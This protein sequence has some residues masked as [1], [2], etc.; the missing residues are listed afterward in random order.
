[1]G[2][3]I[4]SE[5]LGRPTVNSLTQ[6]FKMTE[7]PTVR[8]WDIEFTRHLAG[9]T[10][11]A[12]PSPPDARLFCD[13][14]HLDPLSLPAIKG[15]PASGKTFLFPLPFYLASKLPATIACQWLAID[16]SGSTSIPLALWT[17]SSSGSICPCFCISRPCLRPPL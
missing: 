11:P 5:E 2:N 7:V 6:P 10:V 9:T 16:S 12:Q 13:R 8:L 17:T 3:Q 1:M 14:P 15:A 4:W